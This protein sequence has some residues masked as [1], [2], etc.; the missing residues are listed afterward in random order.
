MGIIVP[1]ITIRTYVHALLYLLH[2]AHLM[3]HRLLDLL[4]LLDFDS[5][6][7]LSVTNKIV[8]GIVTVA[9]IGHG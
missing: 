5:P 1:V 8:K 4:E 3:L 6:R 7:S 9:L 2:L